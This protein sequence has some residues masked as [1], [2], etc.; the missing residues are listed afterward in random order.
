MNVISFSPVIQKFK[1]KGEKSGWT[2]ILVP[3]RIASKLSPKTK[4][5]FRVK[6]KIDNHAVRQVALLPMGEGDFII[7]LN[8][9]MRKH[10]KKA[11][12]DKVSVA[13]E[14]DKSEFVFSGD[15]MACLKDEPKAMANFKKQPPSHQKYFSKW[16]ESAKTDQT[17]VKRITQSVQGLAM[18]LNYGEMIRYFKERKLN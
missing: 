18:G 13:L 15:F 6:G 10:I 1:E 2:Y 17:K 11:V 14:I 3:E 12:G 5:S 8:L 4:V 16:I 9:N 7:P